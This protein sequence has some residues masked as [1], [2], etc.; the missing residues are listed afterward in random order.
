MFF[1]CCQE[2]RSFPPG[3]PPSGPGQP[4]VAQT[5]TTED[6]HVIER[7]TERPMIVEKER[8]IEATVDAPPSPAGSGGQPDGMALPTS[9]HIDSFG[10]EEQG[11]SDDEEV[12]TL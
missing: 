3:P 9:E 8:I 4:P 2:K 7:V 11:H 1:S 6:E 10:F 5:L 12:D